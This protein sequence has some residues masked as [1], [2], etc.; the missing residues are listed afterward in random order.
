[1][2]IAITAGAASKLALTNLGATALRPTSLAASSPSISVTARIQD[3]YGNPVGSAGVPISF[4]GAFVYGSAAS[5]TVTVASQAV[6]GAS[7]VASVPATMPSYNDAYALTATATG[8]TSATGYFAVQSTVTNSIKT[9]AQD[10]ASGSNAFSPDPYLNSYSQAGSSDTVT[11]IFVVTDRYGNSPG[12]NDILNVTFGDTGSTGA[13]TAIVGSS[14]RLPDG[15]PWTITTQPTLVGSAIV[16]EAQVTAT[17]IE[18]GTLSISV[19]D[20]SV[21]TH[22]LVDHGAFHPAR[23]GRRSDPLGERL[24]GRPLALGE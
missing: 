18:S 22:D 6:T 21:A 15:G 4:A 23:C 1:M 14:A 3:A 9:T 17:A 12:T 20:T 16:D 2:R 10:T 7:G 5:A 11:F 13:G 8:L 24:P 19:K